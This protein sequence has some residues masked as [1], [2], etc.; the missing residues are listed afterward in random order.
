MTPERLAVFSEK[1]YMCGASIAALRGASAIAPKFSDVSYFFEKSSQLTSAKSLFP[2]IDFNNIKSEYLKNYKLIL[3]NGEYDLFIIHNFAHKTKHLVEFCDS[4]P[5]LAMLHDVSGVSGLNYAM[6]DLGGQRILSYPNRRRGLPHDGSLA[7]LA[8]RPFAFGAPSMWL[9][10]LAESYLGDSIPVHLIRNCVPPNLFRPIDKAAARGALGLPQDRFI[11]L[12]FAGA[13]AAERKNLAMAAHA[14][15]RAGGD[16]LFV[17]IGGLPRAQV[18]RSSRI[19]FLPAVDPLVDPMR[20]AMLYSAADVFVSV[21]L[22]ENFPNTVL[23]SYHCGTPVIASRVGGHPELVREGSTGWLVDPR[24]PEALAGAIEALSSQPGVVA[25]AGRAGRDLVHA[26]CAEEI[27][28]KQYL[29]AL[30]HVRSLRGRNYVRNRQDPNFVRRENGDPLVRRHA[31]PFYD[32]RPAPT[33]RLDAVARHRPGGPDPFTTPYRNLWN[34]ARS[35]RN[36]LAFRYRMA[37]SGHPLTENE[38]R[39]NSFYNAYRGRRAFLIGNGPSLNACDLSLLRDEI[40]IGVNSIFF[41]ADELGGLPTHYV[42]EDNF[43]AE[44]RADEI[45]RLRGTNKW[46]GNYLRYC[47]QGDDVNWLNVRMRYDAYPGFPFFSLDAG[48]EVWTGGSVTYICM[49]LAFYFGIRELYLIGFDHHYVVPKETEIDGVAYTSKT[50]DPNHF[51]P[52]YFGKGY[53]WHAPM[54]ERM[55]LGYRRAK[56]SFEQFGGRIYNATVGGRLEVFERV[57]YNSLFELKVG[58]TS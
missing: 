22:A 20:P 12:F 7:T 9:K 57:D 52:N 33:S 54:T 25:D 43:V 39:I 16:V 35:E 42:V 32:I 3:Q 47:L 2:N 38:R 8:K 58:Q 19:L 40:T 34:P 44:D 14:A 29:D 1:L 37:A 53:R 36:L 24:R 49:Q 18:P 50:D 31:A 51:D 4:K 26:T 5:T 48:R 30:D 21:S 46:F 28:V 27:C 10:R 55:E 45:N 13:G 6:R 11:V 15:A 23:E 17:A 41:K 56:Q